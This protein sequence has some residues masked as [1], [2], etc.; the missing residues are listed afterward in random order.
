MA[1]KIEYE[2]LY[3]ATKKPRKLEAVVTRAN[4]PVQSGPGLKGRTI[5]RVGTGVHLIVDLNEVSDGDTR[6]VA[7]IGRDPVPEQ[8]Y[9]DATKETIPEW[10]TDGDFHPEW[11]LDNGAFV[12][13]NAEVGTVM[14]QVTWNNETGTGTVIKL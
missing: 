7:I 4:E 9:D 3:W 13:A 10:F 12:P 8:W 1:D 2:K 6:V 5:G 14:F 11:W